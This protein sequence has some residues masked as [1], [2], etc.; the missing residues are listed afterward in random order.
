MPGD[1]GLSFQQLK[2]TNIGIP[3]GRCPFGGVQRQRLWQGV[4]QRPTKRLSAPKRVNPKPVHRTV[5]GE[6]TPC[7]RGRSLIKDT[8]RRVPTKKNTSLS[9]G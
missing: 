7:K 8:A 6:G 1:F 2:K 3:K 9:C 5:F 4:G